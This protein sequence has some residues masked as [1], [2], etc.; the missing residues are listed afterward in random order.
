MEVGAELKF[1]QIMEYDYSKMLM[2]LKHV[3]ISYMFGYVLLVLSI[4]CDSLR[5]IQQ[6]FMCW[7]KAI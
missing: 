6:C 2:K 5:K 1:I 3:I 7:L 4:L